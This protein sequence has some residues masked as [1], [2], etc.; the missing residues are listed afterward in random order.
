LRGLAAGV[1]YLHLTS[2][3]TWLSGTKLIV[4]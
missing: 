2:R 3:S 4:E 1:F